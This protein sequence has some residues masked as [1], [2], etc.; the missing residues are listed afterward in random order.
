MKLTKTE[1]GTLGFTLFVLCLSIYNL[2]VHKSLPTRA[3]VTIEPAHCRTI[4]KPKTGC[5]PQW[6]EQRGTFKEAD[7]TVI[8]ACVAPPELNL[9]DCTDYLMPGEDM[10]VP[11]FI[12]REPPRNPPLEPLK[13]SLMKLN[14]SIDIV[15]AQV[16]YIRDANALTSETLSVLHDCDG[17]E[18]P[19]WNLNRCDERK[20][21][22]LFHQQNLATEYN[23]LPKEAKEHEHDNAAADTR[24]FE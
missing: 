8:S 15:A 23:T 14:R 20:A 6:L 19:I 5:P 4:H 3:T 18:L 13:E 24:N 7:G 9:D 16:R 1:V 10:T 21:N 2:V 22:L 17:A 11:F 12:P